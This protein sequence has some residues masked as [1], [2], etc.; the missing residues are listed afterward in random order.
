MNDTSTLQRLFR[1]KAQADERMT[2]AMQVLDAGSPATEVALRVLGHAYVVDRIFAAHLTSSSHGYASANPVEAPALDSL[3][4]QIRDSDRW[5]VDYVERIDPT[6]LAESIDF[7]FTDGDPGRMSREEILMHVITHGVGHRGQLNWMMTLGGVPPP[8]D[9]FA[10]YLHEAEAST[11]RRTDPAF[12]Q[13]PRARQHHWAEP[14]PDR[15]ALTERIGSALSD[16][17]AFD[18]TLKFDLGD[19]GFVFIDGA[20]VT[21]ENR[22]ADLSLRVSLDD[23]RALSEGSL[24]LIAALASGRLVV[25]D[26]GVAAG[27]RPQ[28]EALLARLR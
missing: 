26:M 7:T 14:F 22:P 28:I 16:G 3:A 17:L 11:R 24:A 27:L 10:N 2:A 5:Y 6:L 25:S 18:R 23:L 20:S 9:G 12:R 8:V 4:G 13:A 15:A 1:H 19:D 21:N